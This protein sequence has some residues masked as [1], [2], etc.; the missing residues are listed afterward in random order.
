MEVLMSAIAVL[1]GKLRGFALPDT[2][3]PVEGTV[4]AGAYEVLEVKM[5]HPDSDSD[6]VRLNVP[7]LTD[8]DT[9]YCVPRAGVD[10]PDRRKP[11]AARVSASA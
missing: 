4:P 1:G 7:R 9:W 8:G 5:N 3:S 10:T 2:R 6:Y 11:P